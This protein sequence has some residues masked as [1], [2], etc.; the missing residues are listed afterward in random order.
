MPYQVAG[1][2]RGEPERP[3]SRVYQHRGEAEAEAARARLAGYDRVDIHEVSEEGFAE[4]EII[5]PASKPDIRGGKPVT[6]E[7]DPRTGAQIPISSLSQQEIEKFRSVEKAIEQGKL[8][9]SQRETVREQI[10]RQA[11]GDFGQRR[12]NLTKQER[13]QQS[14][15]Q[16]EAQRIAEEASRGFTASEILIGRETP[17]GRQRGFRDLPL[18]YQT[19]ETL[20][21][22]A[23]ASMQRQE[24]ISQAVGGEKAVTRGGRVKQ[25]VFLVPQPPQS[26]K[27]DGEFVGGDGREYN[28]ADD[29]SRRPSGDDSGV[30]GFRTGSVS[31]VLQDTSMGD[32][33]DKESLRQRAVPYLTEKY[34]AARETQRIAKE[35]LG[36]D[37]LTRKERLQT[38]FGYTGSL[39]AST[40]LS[41]I[42]EF[43][44]AVLHPIESIKGIFNI[45]TYKRLPS[46]F[47]KDPLGTAA[48]LY[49][50]KK[51]FDV[52]IKGVKT[53]RTIPKR[54]TSAA[55]R[56]AQVAEII[57]AT[58]PTILKADP[59][60]NF[61]D[62]G[63]ET[64][65]V[66]KPEP[67]AKPTQ[68]SF[69]RG[70]K[71]T[72]PVRS[73]ESVVKEAER[74]AV[75]EK[76]GTIQTVDLSR[77]ITFSRIKGRASPEQLLTL[78]KERG[79]IDVKYTV[80]GGFENDF[81][82]LFQY[83][84]GL[85]KP[86]ITI[87]M[88][89][90][91]PVYYKSGKKKGKIRHE[92]GRLATNEELQQTIAHEL[93]HYKTPEAIY[94][95][96]NI[97]TDITG[98]EIPY[99]LQPT[100]IL[101]FGGESY[102]GK[103]GF[104]VSQPPPQNIFLGEGIIR[105]EGAFRQEYPRAKVS[106]GSVGK[107]VPKVLIGEGGQLKKGFK[108]F[109]IYQKQIGR[110][111]YTSLLPRGLFQREAIF[112]SKT[113]ATKGKVQARFVK[114][115]L[116]GDVLTGKQKFQ[117]IPADIKF[118]R[119]KVIV[120]QQEQPL[121][122]EVGVKEGDVGTA[123][124]SGKAFTK[125]GTYRILAEQ[126]KFKR[127]RTIKERFKGYAA[128]GIS[129]RDVAGKQLETLT[130]SRISPE[131]KPYKISK[132]KERRAEPEL[133]YQP[134]YKRDVAIDTFEQGVEGV[135][136]V[137][138]SL[139]RADVATE[140]TGRSV[141]GY[142]YEA[143]ISGFQPLKSGVVYP[144]KTLSKLGKRG[145]LS[146]LPAT[147]QLSK[148]IKVQSQKPRLIFQK[149][150]QP[151]LSVEQAD[152]ILRSREAQSKGTPLF[153]TQRETIQTGMPI[154]VFSEIN[155][156]SK[157]IF[158]IKIYETQKQPTLKRTFG[159]SF[160]RVYGREKAMEFTR[161]QERPRI[162]TFEQAKP[163]TS[164][165][166]QTQALTTTL[167]RTP[168]PTPTPR[169]RITTPPPPPPTFFPPLYFPKS[170]FKE[171]KL[172]KKEKRK[173]KREFF[174]TPSL[175]VVGLGKAAAGVKLTK[176]Q[177]R[178][179]ALINPFQ[180]RKV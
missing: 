120:K 125:R 50:G 83:G 108:V 135:V 6:I 32:K 57:R 150:K 61:M 7:Y 14:A 110:S 95:F 21:S 81:V 93:I 143:E 148:P 69:T 111:Q 72:Q 132:T 158:D 73:T 18:E 176:K 106:E 105:K 87:D 24:V 34:E 75:T 80:S 104:K 65:Q 17:E 117:Y 82:G 116:F 128:T 92:R 84:Y 38:A 114:E 66:L 23:G 37:S 60:I 64:A 33:K 28:L 134:V 56:R 31:N 180:I 101:A 100:E 62:L 46:E 123:I 115:G 4:G 77:P 159:K 97:V 85:K 175:S 70:T 178:G 59:K 130:E 15:R 173:G 12:I 44:S 122:L 88:F 35:L 119:P 139:R 19:P 16:A 29:Y 131:G 142:L 136:P 96:E 45:E 161:V 109:D 1:N 9:P 40:Q 154:K 52:G 11:Q 107:N 152:I 68:F 166:T 147:E 102:F 90:T 167:V 86:L 163:R 25:E 99:K 149:E 79:K 39:L 140:R 172:L 113:P 124:F 3:I 91:T 27:R 20:R 76:F 10:I 133:V 51:A 121:R 127:G 26:I 103:Q 146:L 151:I 118:Q 47:K 8:Q 53:A 137:R 177:L 141:A 13:A 36:S 49:G 155:P 67:I 179:E 129:Q 174:G 2:V 58:K 160:E 157:S 145:Q 168:T 43:T 144:A 78:E 42:R 55:T 162:K 171:R 165:L 89:R 98:K 74:T 71:L 138:K 156:S 153:S 30:F 170:E 5:A 48:G 169:P 164:T 54:I 22:I 41:G 63:L 126:E 94:K 112:L